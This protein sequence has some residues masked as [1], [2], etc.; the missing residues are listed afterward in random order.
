MRKKREP[1]VTSHME[2][3]IRDF[4]SE[5]EK[6]DTIDPTEH[7]RSI[8]HRQMQE[9]QSFVGSDTL[10]T[11]IR[12]SSDYDTKDYDT[13]AILEVAGVKFI[14]VVEGD[15]IFQRV[16]LPKGWKKEAD[17]H[18]LWSKL[19]DDKGRE[20]ASIFF[21]AGKSLG[22]HFNLTLSLHSGVSVD[23]SF[24]EK[25]IGRSAYMLLSCRFEVSFDYDRFDK[26]NVGVANVTD[27]GE[28]VHATEPIFANGEARYDVSDKANKIALEWLDEN[29][30]D[31]RNPGAY[32]G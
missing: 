3:Q 17:E 5:K 2:K 10:P 16:E 7:Q 28:V 13:K 23:S 20:R 25:I 29:Y 19:V 24:P 15:N 18:P 8:E 31:W 11:D 22:P 26:E 32:W 27:S 21:Y 9:Q 1:P 6:F 30:P 4:L 12:H 14:G